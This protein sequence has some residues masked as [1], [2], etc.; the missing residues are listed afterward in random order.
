M[1]VKYTSK[2][3]GYTN[4]TSFSR[5]EKI[6][7]MVSSEFPRVDVSIIDILTK[8]EV[9]YQETSAV[10]QTIG[11]L[12]FAEGCDWDET[13]SIDA[14]IFQ[15]GMYAIKLSSGGEEFNLPII[16]KNDGPPSSIMVVVNTNTWCAYDSCLT[17][18][19]FYDDYLESDN[20]Y[21]QKSKVNP[22]G[23]NNECSVSSFSKPDLCTSNEIGYFLS[24][25]FTP[26][27]SHQ[28]FGETYAWEWLRK[29]GYN[30][31]FVSDLDLIDAS[32]FEGRKLILLNCHPEYWSH[33]MYYNLWDCIN[34]TNTSLLYL[35]GNAIWRKV[36]LNEEKNRIEKMGYP[37]NYVQNE[38]ES[39]FAVDE[40][41][42]ENPVDVC[43]YEI[44]GM[45]YDE[46][47]YNTYATFSCLN[48]DHFLTKGTNWL[49]GEE[50][51][52]D[53]DVQK[54]SG[55]ETDK[56]NHRFITKRMNLENAAL[57]GKGRN[58][59]SGGADIL[60]HTIGGSHVLSAG[61]ITF[62]RCI[63]DSGISQMIKNFMNLIFT[64][65]ENDGLE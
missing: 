19:G 40:F 29:N 15:P 45:F 47:G 59:N 54:P 33:Q 58:P 51:G 44:L 11:E 55:H 46:S 23:R 14:S 60:Y 41:A 12:A 8:K 35:G 50:I 53:Y 38:Y 9:I 26:D 36:L 34:H 25:S 63:N 17:G 13:F 64:G 21:N 28:F 5:G 7:V 30:F 2:I 52:S 20:E 16:I 3:S 27:R 48:E 42:K 22:G 62:G 65:D 37:W 56:V 61:S 4:R 39:G 49:K 57:I 1:A 6:A 32:S 31:D 18:G 10:K 43:P 24:G